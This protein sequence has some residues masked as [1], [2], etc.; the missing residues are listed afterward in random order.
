MN[1]DIGRLLLFIV[2]PL[3]N[4]KSMQRPDFSQSP[5]RVG[6]GPLG[7]PISRCG[8]GF[9]G[10]PVSGLDCSG[11]LRSLFF[12]A[13]FRYLATFAAIHRVCLP[14]RSGLLFYQ[15]SGEMRALLKAYRILPAGIN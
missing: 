15:E 14:V 13:W 3:I 4:Q 2:V 6:S 8:F 10:L 12:I 1:G 7:P 5:K 11:L 9:S